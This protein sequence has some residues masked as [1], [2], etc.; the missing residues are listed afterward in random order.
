V[1]ILADVLGRR[2][3]VSETSEA[4][5][6]GAALLALE[7]AGRIGSIEEFSASVEKVFEPNMLHREIYRNGLERQQRIYQK[8]IT[9]TGKN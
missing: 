2:M 3:V 6:R 8:L 7:A 4:S 9:K 1:Q 5:T